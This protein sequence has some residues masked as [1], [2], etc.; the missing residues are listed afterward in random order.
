[1]KKIK[2]SLVAFFAITLLSNSCKKD[3]TLLN[4]VRT[5]STI[6][7]E[8][9]LAGDFKKEILN[10]K[11]SQVEYEGTSSR[12]GYPGFPQNPYDDIGYNHN[13]VITFVRSSQGYN[14]ANFD[15]IYNK[16]ILYTESVLKDKFTY[17]M[18]SLNKAFETGIKKLFINKHEINFDYINSI[19][20]IS[21]NEKSIL[22]LFVNE[23]A[24]ENNVHVRI[25]KAKVSENFIKN[26][27]DLMQNEKDRLYRFFAVYRYSTLY[28]SSNSTI[29][30]KTI[31][32]LADA[33]FEYICI[34]EGI[35]ECAGSCGTLSGLVSML[36]EML[37]F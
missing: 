29:T 31:G 36:Y 28:W 16:S 26:R 14:S 35:G 10:F 1:M 34:N 4:H 3:T 32:D 8:N 12:T 21:Q 15:F 27:S 13:N 6:N 2:F 17:S 20:E 30:D 23:I 37:A 7:I 5:E 9:S 11:Q 24:N 33:M 19:K 25:A 22:F 18:Q